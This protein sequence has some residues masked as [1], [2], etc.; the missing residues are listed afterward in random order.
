MPQKVKKGGGKGRVVDFCVVDLTLYKHRSDS[1][2]SIYDIENSIDVA[3]KVKTREELFQARDETVVI[4]ITTNSDKSHAAATFAGYFNDLK[5]SYRYVLCDKYWWKTPR[6]L[7]EEYNFN[8]RADYYEMIR[9]MPN[10]IPREFVNRYHIDAAAEFR[11][12]FK[13]KNCQASIYELFKHKQGTILYDDSQGEPQYGGEI[14]DIGY[15]YEVLHLRR[16]HEFRRPPEYRKYSAFL[17]KRGFPEEGRLILPDYL[18]HGDLTPRLYNRAEHKWYTSNFNNKGWKI[19]DL[20]KKRLV[21]MQPLFKFFPHKSMGNLRIIEDCWVSVNGQRHMFELFSSRVHM[22]LKKELSKL[23]LIP[24]RDN[25]FVYL[26]IFL[27]NLYYG[28]CDVHSHDTIQAVIN[29]LD[30]W[31]GKIFGSAMEFNDSK[32]YQLPCCENKEHYME[33]G[34]YLS[35]TNL[36]RTRYVNPDTNSDGTCCYKYMLKKHLPEVPIED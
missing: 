25:R 8:H 24:G 28:F 13:N 3:L 12:L 9:V 32:V 11:A 23:A 4:S 7:K 29:Y 18:A 21:D 15:F 20:K 1:H 10:I 34:P 19:E 33:M 6:R 27:V 14:F 22:N 31:Y 36:R 16:D 35:L 5:K 26:S 2:A 17:K 30:G